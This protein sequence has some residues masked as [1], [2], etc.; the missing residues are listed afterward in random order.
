MLRGREVLYSHAN[1]IWGQLRKLSGCLHDK[2]SGMASSGSANMLANV[3]L[4]LLE[5]HQQ[6]CL[7]SRTG[8]VCSNAT[9]AESLRVLF[10][11]IGAYSSIFLVIS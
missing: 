9:V 3:A 1:A 8:S 5:H 10:D 6:A 2:L 4:L 7:R 11:C